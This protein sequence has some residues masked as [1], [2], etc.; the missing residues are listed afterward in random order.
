M[1]FK[2]DLQKKV[3]NKYKTKK[4]GQIL[5]KKQKQIALQT[6]YPACQ[7]QMNASERISAS[8]CRQVAINNMLSPS[9]FA[10]CLNLK[11]EKN[12]KLNALNLSS[13]LNFCLEII[14]KGFPKCN[15]K[16]SDL[17]LRKAIGRCLT[18]LLSRR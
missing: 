13:S 15:H 7:M 14:D 2:T 10:L 9:F 4:V 8:R 18:L 16:W 1:L 6:F 11:K 12:L 3:I 5:P 17:F